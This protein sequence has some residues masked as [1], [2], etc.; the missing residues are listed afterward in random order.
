MIPP[1]LWNACDFV[2][3]FNS[4]V[5]HIPGKMNTSVNFLSRLELDPNEKITLKI[6]ED[7]PTKPIE[8]N[9]E[10][11]GIPPEEPVFCDTTN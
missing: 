10:S 6:R 9:I 11:T 4:T 7:N 5:A 1:S 8:V 3:Q 2:L